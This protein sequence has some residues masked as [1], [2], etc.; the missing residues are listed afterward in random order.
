MS[1]HNKKSIASFIASYMI[2][3]A[4]CVNA[5]WEITLS[6]MVITIMATLYCL[7][8]LAANITAPRDEDARYGKYRRAGK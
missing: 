7:V 1:K 4:G 3:I 2:V 6:G 8:W 5:G